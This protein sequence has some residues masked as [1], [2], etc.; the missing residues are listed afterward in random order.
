MKR[1]ELTYDGKGIN[2]PD[3]YRSRI[4][5]FETGAD[6]ARYGKLLAAAPVLKA[7]LQTCLAEL[8]AELE[9]DPEASLIQQAVDEARHAL[10]LVD[11]GT[12]G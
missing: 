7:A 11:G 10:S 5:T 9:N 12:N 3:V 2:G 8:E 4:A 1:P 6:A